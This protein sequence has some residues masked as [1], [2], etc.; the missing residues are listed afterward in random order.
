MT[1]HPLTDE[2]CELIADKEDRL[3]TS[4]EKSNMRVAADWQLEQDTEELK[5]ILY[6]IRL[7]QPIAI[8]AI[9][10]EFKQKMRP[11]KDN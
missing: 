4:I 2:M 3:F 9:V 11:Q 6:R 1:D 8:D 10:E 5:I 7:L